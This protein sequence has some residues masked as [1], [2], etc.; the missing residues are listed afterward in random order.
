MITRYFNLMLY[1]EGI[2][3]VVN[4]NQY[5]Q[6]EEWVFTLY[7]QGGVKYTPTTGA[8]VALKSDG[9]LI[10]NAGTVDGE[11]RVVITETQQMTASA[12]KATCELQIDGDTHGTA[13]F[14]LLVEPSPADGGIPSDSDLS[15]FQQA[16]DAVAEM[17]GLL[18]GETV[19][20]KLLPIVQSETGD[21]LTDHITNPS[22]PPIDTSL[23]VAG[24]AADAKVSGDEITD[25]KSALTT[26]SNITSTNLMSIDV[27]DNLYTGS[28]DWNGTWL[29]NNDSACSLSNEYIHG[30]Q[31]C[32][33]VG[34]WIRSWYKL[35][36]AVSG[37][38]YTFQAWVKAGNGSDIRLNIK[39]S[40]A[41][42]T[43]STTVKTFTIPNDTWT[44]I[45][46][47]FTCTGSGTMSPY[48]TSAN[49][50]TMYVARM[51]V[52]EGDSV[53]SLKDAVDTIVAKQNHPVRYGD[54][55]ND[56][57]N[58]ADGTYTANGSATVSGS[59]ATVVASY[60]G[61]LSNE[62]TLENSK[63]KVAVTSTFNV[64]RLA[65]K[66]QYYTSSWQTTSTLFDLTSGTEK[67][68]LIDVS[69]YNASKYRLLLQNVGLTDGVTNTITVDNLGIYDYSDFEAS[70]YY[71]DDF[72]T[73]MGNCIDTLETVGKVF[74]V[75][76]DG[77]GDFTKIV[78][79]VNAATQFMDSV[80]YIGDGEYDIIGE[81][82]S[83]Y[84][85]AV[86]STHN[87][88]IELKNRIHLI[89]S[90]RTVIKAIN[91]EAG[92]TNF[93]N[94][95]TY[96]SVFNAGEYG[97]TIENLTIIDDSIRYSV[98]DD[99]GNAGSTPY[100]NR[101]L[102]CSMTHT[103]GMYPDCIGAGIGEDGYIE[104][105]GCYFDGDAIRNG[106]PV[107]RY[108]YW[109]GNNNSQI[110]NAKGRIFVTDNY[111]CKT[112]TFKLMNYGNSTT[113]TIAYI[114]NNSFG[115][116][117]EIL[118]GSSPNPIIVNMEMVKWNNEIRN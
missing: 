87:W 43:F 110:T 69:S 11:G 74:T 60:D 42:A 104:I 91:V 25:L 37:K 44:K 18:D 73:M 78:D 35:I 13:N 46:A 49:S 67:E 86:D 12:G 47:T 108:V 30:Y 54:I 19:D 27:Q 117:P 39:G 72:E 61:I 102:N 107:T 83:S 116:E 3:P 36:S 28:A 16:V 56:E 85:A 29:T 76:K 82:G 15:L 106:T 64:P 52:V 26:D 71:S 113:K 22:N 94:I 21:W 80:V 111:F 55:I 14:Y 105:R 58:L 112:G 9:H 24:A 93:T 65:F 51:V 20:E 96:F 103:N 23:T 77:T 88:G 38:K 109:H 41:T 7:G 75:K 31:A 95:K 115:S 33:V 66:L 32:E 50:T 63:F 45:E 70:P 92:N 59:T 101:Y 79:A 57:I 97:F 8:I 114:S 6:G 84:M 17:E 2:A 53:F 118:N 40:P 99:L 4:V 5:D 10:A 98:H 68:A 90:A 100:H 48:V 1:K 34:S 62:F 89:G 81:F